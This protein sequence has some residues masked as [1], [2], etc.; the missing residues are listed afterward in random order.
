MGLYSLGLDSL[1]TCA[2]LWDIASQIGAD[3]LFMRPCRVGFV[4]DC[5]TGDES[6]AQA[7]KQSKIRISKL[8]KKLYRM[9][10][11]RLIEA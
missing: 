9:G 11:T 4:F 2:A 1:C 7:Q 8:E 5:N 6:Q 10:C 3:W